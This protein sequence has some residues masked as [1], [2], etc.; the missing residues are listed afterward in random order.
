MQLP[1]G[2]GTK[3]ISWVYKRV[4]VKR[5]MIAITILRPFFRR[6]YDFLDD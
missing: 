3:T 1:L 2:K 5:R 6:K 4:D